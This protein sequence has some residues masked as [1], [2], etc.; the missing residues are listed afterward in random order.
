MNKIEALKQGDTVV[1]ISPAKA[2]DHK[3]IQLVVQLFESWGLKVLVGKNAFGVHGY[4]SGTDR[5]RLQDLQWALDHKEAKAIITTRGG[6]GSV[7]IVDDANYTM[8]RN[9]PKWMVGF[10]DI[11]V[12]HNLFHSKL[13]FP[14]IHAIAPLYLDRLAHSSE[15]LKTLR[16]ALFG[17]ELVYEVPKNPNNKWG[18]ANG[19]VVGGNLAIL[20]SLVGTSI[21]I[22]M[23]GKIL[24]IEEVSEY[25]YQL[26]RMLQGLK[27]AGK[28]KGL[29]GLVVGG[30]TDIKMCEETFGVSPE[31]LIM[32]VVS[33]FN[34]PVLFD[35]PAGHQLD[36]RALVLGCVYELK[37]TGLG[38]SLKQIRNG[39]A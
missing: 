9:Y 27:L 32:Q 12:F 26:D 21:D 34:Y 19:E 11:T 2:I 39:T 22:D 16:K 31:E 29:K 35:F 20:C 3:Y 30:L 8:F 37:V 10:S 15:P 38:A 5:Q 1:I 25:A 17:E 24:F 23:D 33:E 18:N 13:K 6:Y 28:L 14:T 4:F 7:R 36:N